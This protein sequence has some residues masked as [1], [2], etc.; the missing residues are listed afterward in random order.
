MPLLS[1]VAIALGVGLAGIAIVAPL[2][3]WDEQT[4][5]LNAVRFGHGQLR[6]ERERTEA[7]ATVRGFWFDRTIVDYVAEQRGAQPTITEPSRPRQAFLQVERASYPPASYGP[8]IAAV[9][10]TRVAGRGP[11]TQLYAAR[12]AQ[13]LAYIALVAIALVV[14][15]CARP[16]L[17]VLALWPMAIMQATTVSA[18]TLAT[19]LSFVVVA[20]AA[21][22]ARRVA[23][24]RA[25]LIGSTVA[26]LALAL[27]KP[28]YVLFVAVY[29]IG[30]YRHPAARRAI[31]GAVAASAAVFVALAV[32]SSSDYR[33]QRAPV[34]FGPVEAPVDPGAQ[35]RWIEH[36]P[37]R[38][39]SIAARTVRSY[40]RSIARSVV[41]EPPAGVADYPDGE[42]LL[43]VAVLVGALLLG[44]RTD[45]PR[46]DVRIAMAVAAIAV[47]VAVT[48]L[49]Y[50]GNNVT[51]AKAAFGV[52]GR[53]LLPVVAAV[54]VAVVPRRVYG[55][56]WYNAAVVSALV[57][58]AALALHALTRAHVQV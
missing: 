1:F 18:D 16:A 56:R 36:H 30:A 7:G 4:H 46:T 42:R 23:P 5:F 11:K 14:L 52:K 51:G 32:Y 29:T 21:Q 37:S 55:S 50:L 20:C 8:A 54:L 35:L 26:A 19:A 49:I 28:P 10:L 40:G 13:L 25:L 44:R 38:I 2:N 34:A 58:V 9:W 27:V 24:S 43:A 31:I 53:Y 12:L 45:S 15:P 33:D 3:G 22:L 6:Y 17:A 39:P 41:A 47:T 48:A 57:L